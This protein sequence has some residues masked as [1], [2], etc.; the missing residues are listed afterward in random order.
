MIIYKEQIDNYIKCPYMYAI[1]VLKSKQSVIKIKGN[2]AI[3]K[4]LIEI[5]SFE[6]QNNVKLS[7][8]EYRIK[9]TNKYCKKT[10]SLFDTET[11]ATLVKSLNTVFDIFASNAFCGYNVPVE[12]P[13][14]KTSSC[15][16]N[17]IDFV[18]TDDNG[19]ISIVEIVSLN[20]DDMFLQKLRNW[21]HYYISYS[22]IARQFDKNVTV[23]FID[24]VTLKKIKIIYNGDRFEKDFDQLKS[25][26]YPIDNGSMYYNLYNC[27]TCNLTEE[28]DK[29]K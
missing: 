17:L 27:N 5:A 8:S 14:A 22:Y 12:I 1:N 24:P 26:I 10:E 20:D 25:V 6:M 9:F 18:L 11:E 15:Y 16:R 3:K 23:Y 13:I 4:H 28:C 29:R 21:P 19:N 7:L 2:N